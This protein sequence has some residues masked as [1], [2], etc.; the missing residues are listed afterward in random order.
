M[1]RVSHIHI[2]NFRA[3]RHV[4]LLL[5]DL[6]PLVGQNNTGKS[7]VLSAIG[8]VLSPSALTNGDFSDPSLPVTVAACIEGID[9]TL[10][11]T[12]PDPKHRSAMSPYIVD[13]KLW[14]RISAA[15][16]GKKPTQQVWEP[17]S[18]TGIGIP[19]Q[20]RAY[21]TGLPEAVSALL[22]EPLHIVA[23]E[24]LTEDLGKAKSGTT[25]KGLLDEVMAPVLATHESLSS[26][27]ATIREILS[28][29]GT[30]RSPHLRTFDKKATEAL[31]DFFPGLSLDVD[32]PIV[33]LKEFFRAGDLYVTDQLTGE[34]RRFDQMGTGTQRAIQMA[35]VRYLAEA[36]KPENSISYRRLLL[37]DEPEL[38]LHP[39]G[40]RHLR[41]A[42]RNLAG[43]GF[44]VVFSTHSP[45]MLSK[46]IAPDT[47]IVSRKS[48]GTTVRRPLRE[49][50]TSALSDSESQSRAL[51]QLGNVAEIYFCE[52]IILCEGKTELRLLPLA[53]ER[54]YGHAPEL[55]RICFV[56][57]GSGSD[58]TKGLPVLHVMGISAFAVA[59]L[60]FAFVEARKGGASAWLSKDADDLKQV[61]AILARLSASSGLP[62]GENGLPIKGGGHT[63][64]ETWAAF[65]QDSE[66][67]TYAESAHD[68]L[69]AKGVWLWSTGCIEH[70][71]GASDKGEDAIFYQENCLS[72]LGPS[73]IEASMPALKAL[74]EWIRSSPSE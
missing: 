24:D 26:A 60:D 27:L 29:N 5:G 25:I 68:A 16:A 64:A 49:A 3:C 59:D 8:L 67:K 74:F 69:I 15:A 11:A 30:E 19:E 31:A 10:L 20:W 21:P 28:T 9:A 22:P 45:L 56:S 72:V 33:D 47:V 1:H 54:I 6:T 34:R 39:Q 71:I 18:Y 4:S 55:D 43:A 37:I 14:I 52:K 32:L 23:M 65:A 61:K 12:I 58:I 38:F 73:E 66:G 36:R 63:A 62:L 41:E 57:L 46:E 13:E 7:T 35:L 70:V 51:F 2:T 17:S 44:Q 50:V 42:L 48:T 40:V 53:Y